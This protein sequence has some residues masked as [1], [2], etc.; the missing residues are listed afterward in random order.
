[1][2]AFTHWTDL[3]ISLAVW[4]KRIEQ[5]MIAF[6]LLV[7]VVSFLP[8]FLLVGFEGL[9]AVPAGEWTY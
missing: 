6:S 1:M 4:L 3:P 7:W 5:I 8:S 9:D 2:L